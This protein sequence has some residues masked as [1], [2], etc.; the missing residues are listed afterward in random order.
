MTRRCD[1][2]SQR[3]LRWIGFAAAMIVFASATPAAA[4]PAAPRPPAPTP[5]HSLAEGVYRGVLSWPLGSYRF[6]ELET[7]LNG[8]WSLS[9]GSVSLAVTGTTVAG[10]WSFEMTAGGSG[11]SSN[12]RS[13]YSD[14]TITAAGTFEGDANA[15][16]MTGSMRIVGFMLIN[17][18]SDMFDIPVDETVPL[19]C[20]NFRWLLSSTTCTSAAGEWTVPLAESLTTGSG[21]SFPSNGTFALWRVDDTVPDGAE[22]RAVDELLVEMERIVNAEPFDGPALGVVLRRLAE[23]EGNAARNV[24]CGARDAENTRIAGN[25]LYRLLE[26]RFGVADPIDLPTLRWMAYAA[27]NTGLIGS[28]TP[29]PERAAHLDHRFTSRL[30]LMVDEAFAAGDARA[31]ARI[32]SF[33]GQYGWEQIAAAASGAYDELTGEG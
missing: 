15:P 25:F 30:A 21:S 13:G 29:Q 1:H 6:S 16:C 23:F 19:E 32:E 31:L 12:E 18:G 14:A 24:E 28:A 11:R 7:T 20:A 4:R 33:A 17:D 22:D 9:N 2:Q 10:E 5:T 26:D 8:A 3:H 27:L